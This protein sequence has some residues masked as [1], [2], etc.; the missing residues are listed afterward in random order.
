MEMDNIDVKVNVD[1]S[2]MEKVNELLEESVDL[3]EDLDDALNIPSL[4]IRQCREC[5]FNITINGGV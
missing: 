4:T 2:D 3:A 5:T 1:T